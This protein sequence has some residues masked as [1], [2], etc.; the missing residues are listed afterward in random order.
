MLRIKNDSCWKTDATALLLYSRNLQRHGSAVSLVTAATMRLNSCALL[1]STWSTGSFLTAQRCPSAIVS[2]EDGHDPLVGDEPLCVLY[3]PIVTPPVT[4]ENLARTCTRRRIAPGDSRRNRSI[5][6]AT[7]PAARDGGTSRVWQ[8]GGQGPCRRASS[9]DRARTDPIYYFR[10]SDGSASRLVSTKSGVDAS[11]L[12]R[13]LS[14][15][16]RIPVLF[17]SSLLR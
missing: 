3:G 10:R 6:R 11:M 9:R 8:I 15:Y 12:D 17:I 7:V 14:S 1:K 4:V 13:A 5:R 2:T 16:H